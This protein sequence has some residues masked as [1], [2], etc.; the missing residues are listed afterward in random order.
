MCDNQGSTQHF[1]TS[2]NQNSFSSNYVPYVGQVFNSYEEA[3]IAYF[4]Y[5]GRVSFSV[6]KGSTKTIDGIIV[7]EGRVP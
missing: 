6:R 2:N 1:A 4:D 7:L 3:Q 5:A